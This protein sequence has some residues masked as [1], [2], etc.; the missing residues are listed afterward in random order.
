[1][2]IELAHDLLAKCV[3]DIASIEAKSRSRA[4]NLVRDKYAYFQNNNTLALSEG[5]LNY[6]R[7]LLSQI[8]LLPE[9]EA[10][11][12]HSQKLL[13][14]EK[15]RLKIRNY[16]IVA[17]SI[18]VF[19]LPFAAIGWYNAYT[20]SKIAQLAQKETVKTQDSLNLALHEVKT[21]RKVV[22]GEEP[23]SDLNEVMPLNEPIAAKIPLPSFSNVHLQGKVLDKEGRALA[24]TAVEFMGAKVL[25]HRDGSFDM[26][27]LLPPYYMQKPEL[28]ISIHTANGLSQEQKFKPENEVYLT[29]KLSAQ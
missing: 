25:T 21:L 14:K 10:F 6:V 8:L 28:S 2:K 17:L 4:E 27:L 18:S 1:M 20:Q 22:V 11:V 3:F 12:Q 16:A 29:I 5:D 7:P 9:E 26:F 23:G 13:Q 19:V 15:N 24:Q